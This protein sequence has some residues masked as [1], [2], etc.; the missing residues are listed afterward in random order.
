MTGRGEEPGEPIP[1]S[2]PPQR[3]TGG[4]GGGGGGGGARVVKKPVKSTEGRKRGGSCCARGGQRML[5]GWEKSRARRRRRLQLKAASPREER[6]NLQCKAKRRPHSSREE[7]KEAGPGREE[8]P[9]GQSIVRRRAPFLLPEALLLLSNF[10][11]LSLSISRRSFQGW[12][13]LE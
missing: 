3:P 1:P 6:T 7:G 13:K 5:G 8:S 11:S 10:L 2:V 9:Q 4:G 12:R